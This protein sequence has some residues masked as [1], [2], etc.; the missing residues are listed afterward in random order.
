MGEIKDKKNKTA[1]LAFSLWEISPGQREFST[2]LLQPRIAEGPWQGTARSR[3]SPRAARAVPR[4]RRWRGVRAGLQAAREG[5]AGRPAVP[6]SRWGVGAGLEAAHK[7]KEQPERAGAAQQ[8]RDPGGSRHGRSAPCRARPGGNG[9][10]GTPHGKSQVL[11]L[12]YT[13]VYYLFTS[14]FKNS[15][16]KQS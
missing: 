15:S 6:P 5:R 10:A 13:S 3:G 16:R 11:S 1:I 4:P 2:S 9:G 7:G 8:R 12:R 14:R